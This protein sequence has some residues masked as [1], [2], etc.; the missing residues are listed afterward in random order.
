ML[1]P[2]HSPQEVLD[3]VVSF[4]EPSH[5]LRLEPVN[6][7][8]QR[9][10][11]THW[12][13]WLPA[14]QP[15]LEDLVTSVLLGESPKWLEYPR[16]FWRGERLTYP[17]WRVILDHE[18]NKAAKFLGSMTEVR[19][20]SLYGAR[21]RPATGALRGDQKDKIDGLFSQLKAVS[22]LR[23]DLNFDPYLDLCSVRLM[24]EHP[25]QWTAVPAE[26]LFA[27]QHSPVVW[28]PDLLSDTALELPFSHAA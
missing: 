6:R 14:W 1:T 5:R 18:Q 21:W 24:I 20:L 11:H 22:S 26:A 15:R 17:R 2:H 7:S 23:F 19:L 16:I 12:P 25:N 10:V 28:R 27:L 13:R 8:F 9:S 3:V 4:V